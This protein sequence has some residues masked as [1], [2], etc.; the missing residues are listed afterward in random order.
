MIANNLGTL[1]I[2]SNSTHWKFINFLGLKRFN[3]VNSP[4]YLKKNKEHKSDFNI[5]SETSFH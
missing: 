4:H 2:P 5:N 3:A 1:I